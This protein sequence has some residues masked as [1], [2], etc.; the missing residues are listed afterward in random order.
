M[1]D[2]P[3][4]PPDWPDEFSLLHRRSVGSTNDD[5]RKVAI[6]GADDGLVIRADAQTNGRGRR[7]REWESPVG[8]LYFSIVLRPDKALPEAAMISL[9]AAVSLGDALHR[10][11]PADAD[12]QHKWPNDILV[13]GAKIAGILLEAS[14]GGALRPVEWIVLGCGV[15]IVS[16]PQN[17]LYPATDLGCYPIAPSAAEI[18][19]LFIQRF[20]HWRALWIEDGVA[21]IRSAWLH[22]AKGLGEP[23][24]VR[25]GARE[26]QGVFQGLDVD[27]ALMLLN[28]N[29]T[30]ERVT[31]GDV[32]FES[33]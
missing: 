15:N 25:T 3:T 17:T 33:A 29:G 24:T 32:F 4:N 7:G 10:V 27:G 1:G 11:L 8:N 26:S 30:I 21:P 12:I 18:L 2:A 5:A 16:H 20:S 28:A 14:G 13:D 23:V 6:S 31:A 9:L 19:T 22:R